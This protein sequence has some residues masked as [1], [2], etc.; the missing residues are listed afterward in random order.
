MWGDD[1]DEITDEGRDDS[2]DGDWNE[3]GD[4]DK[5]RMRRG[6]RTWVTMRIGM[7][8]KMTFN[9]A[10]DRDTIPSKAAGIQCV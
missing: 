10:R 8:M 3:D 4:M 2:K 7:K 9:I 6:A 1:V 5:A